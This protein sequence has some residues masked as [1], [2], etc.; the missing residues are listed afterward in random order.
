MIL[1]KY[2]ITYSNGISQFKNLIYHRTYLNEIELAEN[3]IYKI[4]KANKFKPT[5]ESQALRKY[6][7]I[8]FGEYFTDK[9]P[10]FKAISTGVLELPSQQGLNHNVKI[11]RYE[12]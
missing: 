5:K 3:E 9:S 1:G 10:L 6:L 12:I 4:E 7:K 8:T 2:K 11:I